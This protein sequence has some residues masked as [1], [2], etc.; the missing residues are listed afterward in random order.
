M[1]QLILCCTVLLFICQ[2]AWGQDK[3][4]WPPEWLEGAWRIKEMESTFDGRP[5]KV[6]NTKLFVFVGNYSFGVERPD[7]MAAL[8]VKASSEMDGI[9]YCLL[10]RPWDP[11]SPDIRASFRRLENGVEV[12]WSSPGREEPEKKL[13]A[14]YVLKRAERSGLRKE[15]EAAAAGTESQVSDEARKVL[16]E[17]L[18]EMEAERS[19]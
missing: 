6:I 5:F 4:E 9:F 19:E 3:E 2:S 18:Y 17:W 14:T 12:R 1:K 10:T 16:A 13:V 15:S 8:K 7:L 11:E